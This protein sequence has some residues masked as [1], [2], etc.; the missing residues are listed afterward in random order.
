[1]GGIVGTGAL[2]RPVGTANQE[3]SVDDPFKC[4]GMHKK[5]QS[6]T[7]TLEWSPIQTLTRRN[8]A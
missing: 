5:I 6:A 1:V 2:S 8:V 3:S 4:P 7:D